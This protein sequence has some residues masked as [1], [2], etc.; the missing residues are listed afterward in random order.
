MMQ[1]FQIS[2]HPSSSTAC[3][4]TAEKKQQT[5]KTM[6]K[7]QKAKLKLKSHRTASLRKELELTRKKNYSEIPKTKK[8]HTII[9]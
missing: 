7:K 5:E 1:K 8:M 3:K 9:H 4:T 2:Y 6:P